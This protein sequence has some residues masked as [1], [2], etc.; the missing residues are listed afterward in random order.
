M[1]TTFRDL[2]SIYN[3]WPALVSYLTSV[4][5]GSLRVDDL[6]TP[7]NPYAL[8]RYVKGKS[9]MA[10]EHVRAFRSVV[11]DTL[12]HRPVS[13]TPFKSTDGECLPDTGTP[14][15]YTLEHFVDGVMIGMWYD[16]Y[17]CSWRYHTRS[18]I[19]A[20]CRYYSQ[21]RSFRQMFD[22]ATSVLNWDTLDREACYTWVLQDPDNRIVVPVKTPIAHLVM[23]AKVSSDA[24]VDLSLP[25]PQDK[26]PVMKTQAPATWDDVKS[27]VLD[28]N[29]RFGHTVQGI[30]IKDAQGRR[31]KL[32]TAEY[33]RVRALRGNTARRDFVWLAAWRSNTL[34]AYL[35]LYP[36]ER[37][38]SDLAIG[39][40]KRI[41]NDVFHM[42]V[43]V[44]KARSLPKTA[45]PPKYRPLV[46][47][48][49]NK[50]MTELKPAGKTVNW[51]IVLEYM[52]SRDIPQMLY[53]INWDSRNA[54]QQLGLSSIPLEPPTTA[55]TTTVT[56]PVLPANTT[57]DKEDIYVDM[58]A[59]ETG[60]PALQTM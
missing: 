50:F 2:L 57:D 37:H 40:W 32:R 4:E 44:F 16:K 33:N 58:P 18:T 3:T 41:S 26:N 45:I 1:S 24:T 35:S 36:E 54:Q 42:Y 53:V 28:W 19:G 5:G 13:V 30:H 34:P 21:T 31:W 38:G 9:D 15:A 17:S 52:N 48:I 14:S 51:Q 7:D 55:A 22:N 60:M 6:S 25:L 20:N 11:W 56:E 39:A 46:Y 10:L 49:H 43:D 23:A 47:G 27:R 12:E 29:S 59:L 8:I